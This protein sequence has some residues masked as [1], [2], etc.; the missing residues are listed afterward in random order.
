MGE[1]DVT[2]NQTFG[3]RPECY[4]AYGC[5]GDISRAVEF[6]SPA[7]FE[8]RI[9]LSAIVAREGKLVGITLVVSLNLSQPITTSLSFGDK[10]IA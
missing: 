1:Y 5:G 9:L 7:T 8:V 10:R 2:K 3:N 6:P 4:I